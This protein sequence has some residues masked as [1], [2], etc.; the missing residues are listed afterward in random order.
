[1]NQ[2]SNIISGFG[3]LASRMAGQWLIELDPGALGTSAPTGEVDLSTQIDLSYADAHSGQAD[4]NEWDSQSTQ[5]NGGTKL[6]L[7]TGTSYD[8]AGDKVLYAFVRDLTFDDLG[9]L[10][11]VSAERRVS[12]DVTETC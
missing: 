12:I 5:P 6:T 7:Q 11:S 9:Q 3:I 8:A 2:S 4:A 1:M 10:A